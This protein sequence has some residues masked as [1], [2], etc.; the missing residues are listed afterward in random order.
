MKGLQNGLL[1]ERPLHHIRFSREYFR[2][3][4]LARRASQT[5]IPNPSAELDGRDRDRS[6]TGHPVASTSIPPATLS[7]SSVAE[8]VT[9]GGDQHGRGDRVVQDQLADFP[10]ALRQR[11]ER[12][13]HDSGL[14]LGEDRVDVR[15]I[16][17][18]AP[19]EVEEDKIKV[20][21]VVFYAASD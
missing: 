16:V 20:E 11:L 8:K 18:P 14:V 17:V 1:K 21:H 13:D 2:D 12:L 9:K 6:S 4:S 10:E 5:P 3:S 7:A 19:T 15:R